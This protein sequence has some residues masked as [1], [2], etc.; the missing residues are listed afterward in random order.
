MEQPFLSW[1]LTWPLGAVTPRHCTRFQ[2]RLFH[3]VPLY[4]QHALKS[5][6]WVFGLNYVVVQMGLWSMYSG[7]N[8]LL[9]PLS[10]CSKN[11]AAPTAVL[12]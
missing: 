8:L 5:V 2:N 6:G 3:S 11:Q 12:T 9:L 1:W 10:S 4:T 7:S